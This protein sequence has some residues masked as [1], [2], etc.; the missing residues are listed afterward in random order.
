MM[1]VMRPAPGPGGVVTSPRPDRVTP[2]ASTLPRLEASPAGVHR[3]RPV[4]PPSTR[5]T[6]PVVEAASG[7]ASGAIAWATSSA[8]TSRRSG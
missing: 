5:R 2:R 1:A 8:E 7:E 4:M 3:R 6:A